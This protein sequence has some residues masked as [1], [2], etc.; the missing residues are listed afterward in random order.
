M[1]RPDPAFRAPVQRGG[2]E[3]PLARRQ[4]AGFAARRGPSR[5]SSPIPRVDSRRASLGSRGHACR[6]IKKPRAPAPAAP[7]A[8]PLP[9]ER[10]QDDCRRILARSDLRDHRHNVTDRRHA[11]VHE[12]Q[13]EI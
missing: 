3:L 7:P 10:P 12:W 2:T 8:P 6:E 13:L 4:G 9:P 1:S 11:P 5:N